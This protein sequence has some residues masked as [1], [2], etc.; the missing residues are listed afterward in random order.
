MRTIK[1]TYLYYKW[2]GSSYGGYLFSFKHTY[3]EKKMS[4]CRFKRL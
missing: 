2:P 4:Y 1:L 3:W